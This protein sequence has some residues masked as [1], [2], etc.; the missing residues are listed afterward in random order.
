[1]RGLAAEQPAR[2]QPVEGPVAARQR[3]QV[4]QVQHVAEHARHK[5][6]G[7]LRPAFAVMH[8]H[9]VLE[10]AASGQLHHGVAAPARSRLAPVC[11][12]IMAA[13]A[14]MVGAS[15]RTEMGKSTP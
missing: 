2:L 6:E 9:K 14:A 12:A 8:G 1:M 4:T 5:E 13:Q 10:A 7:R 3:G 11:S 15:N